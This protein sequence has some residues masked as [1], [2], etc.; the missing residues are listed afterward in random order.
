MNDIPFFK[1]H[2]ALDESVV[3]L[4]R[5]ILTE[6][7]ALWKCLVDGH[8][9]AQARFIKSSMQQ[10]GANSILFEGHNPRLVF[11]SEQKKKDLELIFSLTGREDWPREGFPSLL[12][13]ITLQDFCFTDNYRVKP[14]KKPEDYQPIQYP[15]GTLLSIAFEDY[16]NEIN[17]WGLSF[18][19]R[20][21]NEVYDGDSDE[22]REI[23]DVDV[24]LECFLAFHFEHIN[25]TLIM[26]GHNLF[27]LPSGATFLWGTGW[28]LDYQILRTIRPE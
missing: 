4:L 18:R 17:I 5:R 16:I 2:Y 13:M 22:E 6:R 3:A 23:W 25:M 27:L 15:E 21:S 14:Y 10:S 24:Y 26:I 1:D 19:G 20:V 9:Q 28:N 11:R 8:I 7:Y 12:A